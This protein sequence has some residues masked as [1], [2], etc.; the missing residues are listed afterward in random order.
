MRQGAI[1]NN[2]SIKRYIG[3]TGFED[4]EYSNHHQNRTFNKD[5]DPGVYSY[6][7]VAKTCR[8]TVS[9]AVELAVGDILFEVDDSHSV[10]LAKSVV[11]KSMMNAGESGFL[12]FPYPKTIEERFVKR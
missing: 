10:G 2:V 4:A 11:F 12:G 5:A 1:R 9:L 7:Q 6:A 3:S 8:Q